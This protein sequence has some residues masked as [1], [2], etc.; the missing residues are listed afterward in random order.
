[1]DGPSDNKK[2]LIAFVLIVI[3][4]VGACYFF[5]RSGAAEAV[6]ETV[7]AFVPSPER[8]ERRMDAIDDARRVTDLVNARQAQAPNDLE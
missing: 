2:G 3:A 5:Q 1:M 8:F 7:D 4:I 6:D